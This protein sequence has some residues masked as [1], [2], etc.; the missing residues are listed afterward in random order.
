VRVK[1]DLSPGEWA[2]LA[3]LCEEP[4]HGYAVAALMAPDGAIGRVWTLR[5]PMTYRAIAT[6]EGL[7]L[8]AV[9][10]V[11]AGASAPERRVMRATPEA[12]ERIAAWLERPVEHVRDLRGLLLL[13]LHFLRC[14]DEPAAALLRAQRAVLARQELALAGRR[15]DGDDPS[16]TLALWRW[17]MT[18]A[19]LRFVDLMLAEAGAP[20]EVSGSDCP[21]C[22]SGT[23]AR[24][25]R[26]PLHID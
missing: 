25:P 19:A 20:A 17:S 2:V 9:D 4:R 3:L 18:D 7:G 6:L 15:E 23:A 8:V 21:L 14:R 16:R 24:A 13:K 1:H 11:Q 12:H 10:T 22:G 26:A 5:R